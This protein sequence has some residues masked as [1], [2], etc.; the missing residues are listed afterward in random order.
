MAT[1]SMRKYY[2]CIDIHKWKMNRRR[3]FSITQF[4][5]LFFSHAIF[6]SVENF[7]SYYNIINNLRIF[8]NLR[9]F[10]RDNE[11][12]SNIL[13]NIWENDAFWIVA[14]FIKI[15]IFFPRLWLSI[16]QLNCENETSYIDNK[17]FPCEKKGWI[18]KY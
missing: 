13:E 16:P 11:G 6:F 7:T 12:F 10:F 3:D 9:I 14:V 8:T 15:W 17:I 18:S 1:Y 4:F 2:L 5:S